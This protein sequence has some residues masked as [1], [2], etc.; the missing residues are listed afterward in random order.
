MKRKKNPKYVQRFLRFLQRRKE[1]LTID[2]FNT[3]TRNN[4]NNLCEAAIRVIKEI[5]LSRMKAHKIAA[6]V[7][8]IIQEFNKYLDTKVNKSL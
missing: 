6:L 5:I 4:T 3:T 2:R 7:D 1:W 8:F